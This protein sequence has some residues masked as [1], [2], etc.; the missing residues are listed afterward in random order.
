[1]KDTLSLTVTDEIY[2]YDYCDDSSR[3]GAMIQPLSP[4]SLSSLDEM[5]VYDKI[6]NSAAIIMKFDAL[7]LTLMLLFVLSI[8][9]CMYKIWIWSFKDDMKTSMTTYSRIKYGSI[10]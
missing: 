7:M 8:M 3:I 4:E 10:H 5:R 1:M 9:I 6:S 2:G